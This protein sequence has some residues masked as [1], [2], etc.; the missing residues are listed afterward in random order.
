MSARVTVQ[1]CVWPSTVNTFAIRV[2]QTVI[3]CTRSPN[4]LHI[5]SRKIV[6]NV[7]DDYSETEPYSSDN[8]IRSL[9]SSADCSSADRTS[10]DATFVRSK[11]REQYY[12]DIDRYSSIVDTGIPRVEPAQQ[13]ASTHGTDAHT[14][15]YDCDS[16]TSETEL[17]MSAFSNA[18]SDIKPDMQASK[19]VGKTA[20]RKGTAARGAEKKPKLGRPRLDAKLDAKLKSKKL[21]VMQFNTRHTNTADYFKN[22]EEVRTGNRLVI[23]PPK[24]CYADNSNS[25]QQKIMKSVTEDIASA[26]SNHDIIHIKNKVFKA[27]TTT[28]GKS[29]LE[30]GVHMM[31]LSKLR[32]LVD[33]S[34]VR[35]IVNDVIAVLS[36][37][38]KA[39]NLNT[40]LYI[41]TSCK[42]SFNFANT[43]QDIQLVNRYFCQNVLRSEPLSTLIFYTY[44]GKSHI[45]YHERTNIVVN[46]NYSS[47]KISVFSYDRSLCQESLNTINTIVYKT[48][49]VMIDTA[50]G[51]TKIVL[52][53]TIIVKNVTYVMDCFIIWRF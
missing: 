32:D 49:G 26:R 13:P 47:F 4:H 5:M 24:P 51:N 48:N 33:I 18:S 29:I 37:S 12:K 43:P 21:E 3:Q 35:R 22:Q 31:E 27:D 20:H 46:K 9:E 7:V 10:K 6:L 41:S 38:P 50:Y 2:T 17:D 30:G 45:V 39:F 53:S 34:R 52:P 1:A 14:N 8:S 19:P 11:F 28:T 42:K 25:G 40:P 15:I 44:N 23:P 16:D 36:I